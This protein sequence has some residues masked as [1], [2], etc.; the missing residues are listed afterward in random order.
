M[1]IGIRQFTFLEA[2][3][4][5]Y[6]RRQNCS[7]KDICRKSSLVWGRQWW[8]LITALGC[9]MR[10]VSYWLVSCQFGLYPCSHQ[11]IM[12]LLSE[13]MSLG[14][15]AKFVFPI[16]NQR[17][18]IRE[19]SEIIHFWACNFH[20][21]IGNLITY[22]EQSVSHVMADPTRKDLIRIH[23]NNQCNRCVCTERK[24][25]SLLHSTL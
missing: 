4:R 15:Q 11:L 17:P 24:Y 7:S 22:I 13:F 5:Y 3:K 21:F 6:S 19:Q 9:L 14:F 18:E 2:S 10:T 12:H 8:W 1:K 25:W 20:P 16:R 23:G